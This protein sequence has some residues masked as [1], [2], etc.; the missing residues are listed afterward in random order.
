MQVILVTFLVLKLDKLRSFKDEQLE[1][2]LHIL[3][4]LLVLKLD[5]LISFKDEQS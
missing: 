3:I 1:N 5:K 2:I 4:T